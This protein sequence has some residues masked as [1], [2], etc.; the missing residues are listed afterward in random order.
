M[1]QWTK[2]APVSAPAVPPLHIPCSQAQ[3]QKPVKYLAGFHWLQ[4]LPLI[5][6]VFK[7]KAIIT[8]QFVRYYNL[9][10]AVK[11]QDQPS[12]TVLVMA[13]IPRTQSQLLLISVAAVVLKY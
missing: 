4:I 8:P 9:G 6:H 5:W 10:V 7:T 12:P 1:L 13:L 11:S 2:A 3:T